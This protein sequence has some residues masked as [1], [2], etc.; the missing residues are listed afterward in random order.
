MSEVNR[1]E[2]VGFYE[3]TGRLANL[4]WALQPLLQLQAQLVGRQP[5][6]RAHPLRPGHAGPQP[7]AGSGAGEGGAGGPERQPLWS[8][9]G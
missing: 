1:A 9:C 7:E 8:H 2:S 6:L 4:L 3:Q 5:E